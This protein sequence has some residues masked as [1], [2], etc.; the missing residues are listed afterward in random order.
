MR[1]YTAHLIKTFAGAELAGELSPQ[2]AV[3]VQVNPLEVLEACKLEVQA[4]WAYAP[5]VLTAGAY[6]CYRAQEYLCKG[7]RGFR[8]EESA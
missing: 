4:D 2:G 1:A 7:F 6:I 5:N 3:R 8:T